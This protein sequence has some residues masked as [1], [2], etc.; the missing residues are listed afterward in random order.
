MCTLCVHMCVFVEARGWH[1]RH[2]WLL[3]TLLLETWSLTDL[4]CSDLGR[5]TIQLSPGICHLHLP[6]PGIRPVQC[7]AWLWDTTWVLTLC[8]R[9][10]I[11]C[12]VFLAHL[13][14][15]VWGWVQ[16]ERPQLPWNIS[17]HK[18]RRDKLETFPQETDGFVFVFQ[19]ES[20]EMATVSGWFASLLWIVEVLLEG[21]V[22]ILTGPVGNWLTDSQGTILGLDFSLPHSHLSAGS[23]VKFMSMRF[24]FVYF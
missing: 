12:L 18:R 22:V 19:A 20:S 1:V 6:S 2:P 8:S 7:R 14:H 16:E 5:S 15:F 17:S 24:L 23:Y 4:E 3:S 9:H 11:N 21:A 10:F 13:R